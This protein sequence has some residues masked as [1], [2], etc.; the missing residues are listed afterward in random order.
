ML[1][2]WGPETQSS[3]I[4]TAYIPMVETERPP[5]FARGPA[6]ARDFLRG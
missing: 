2:W 1:I 3:S 6:A 5:E 4:M